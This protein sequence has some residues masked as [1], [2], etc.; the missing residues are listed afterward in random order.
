MLYHNINLVLELETEI[1]W[2]MKEVKQDDLKAVA[3]LKNLLN[4][5]QKQK[6]PMGYILSEGS[7]HCA[8]CYDVMT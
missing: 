7:N 4:A 5:S 3:G 8:G 1:A 2:F 6:I